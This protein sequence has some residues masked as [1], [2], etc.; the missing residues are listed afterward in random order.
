[1]NFN[2]LLGLAVLGCK[3]A[4]GGDTKPA[5]VDSPLI[6]EGRRLASKLSWN[7]KSVMETETILQD[8]AKEAEQALFN[9]TNM[10]NEEK[11]KL[12]KK[13]RYI[14]K[15]CYD[16]MTQINE[17]EIVNTE[18]AKLKSQMSTEEQ[19]VLQTKLQEYNFLSDEERKRIQKKIRRILNKL[20]ERERD[21]E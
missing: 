13:L 17:Q 14:I 19:E 20:I 15:T 5:L 1:M 9:F 3:L 16:T 10:S 6:K 12:K 18:L 7:D 11:N 8:E 4:M 21:L 2:W